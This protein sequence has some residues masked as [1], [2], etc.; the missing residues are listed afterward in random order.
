[1]QTIFFLNNVFAELDLT[2]WKQLADLVVDIAI[3][4]INYGY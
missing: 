4:D 1:M 3:W 2:W